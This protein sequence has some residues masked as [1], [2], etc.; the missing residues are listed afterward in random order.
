[1]SFYQQISK[2]IFVSIALIWFSSCSSVPEQRDTNI[3]PTTEQK[4]IG[5][6]KGTDHKGITAA[7]VFHKDKKAE[8]VQGNIIF[9]GKSVGGIVT[10]EL[11]DTKNPINLDLVMTVDGQTKRLPM[12]IQFISNSKIQIRKGDNL[13]IRPTE[14]SASDKVNRITLL[15]Q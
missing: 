15:K 4:I 12:I 9:D 6:W 7:F 13:T 11:D 3:R 14:F 2:L 10:W 5:V 8:M 1:M